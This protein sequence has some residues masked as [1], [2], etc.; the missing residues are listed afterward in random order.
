MQGSI[1][2]FQVLKHLENVE[3]CYRD[4]AFTKLRT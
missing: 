1:A 3:K 2:I 4:V